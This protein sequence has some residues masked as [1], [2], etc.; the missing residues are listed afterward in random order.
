MIMSSAA[1]S[2]ANFLPKGFFR[3]GKE[4]GFLGNRT[5]PIVSPSPLGYISLPGI[6]GAAAHVQAS[7]LS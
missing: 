7:C 3:V 1:D 6:P 5:G 4:T 2:N